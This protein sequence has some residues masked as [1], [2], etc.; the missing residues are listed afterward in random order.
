MPELRPIGIGLREGKEQIT[1]HVG[2]GVFIDS[3][4]RGS[5]RT[6]DRTHTVRNAA[7]ADRFCDLPGDIHKILPGGR[8]RKLAYGH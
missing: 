6:E 1:H 7:V 2:V 5:V 3:N 8:K 4:R